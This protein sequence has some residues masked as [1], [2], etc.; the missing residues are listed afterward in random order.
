MNEPFAFPS[1]PLPQPDAVTAI[2]FRNQD[3]EN[4]AQLGLALGSILSTDMNRLVVREWMHKKGI[5]RGRV[6]KHLHNIEGISP[7]FYAIKRNSVESVYLLADLGFDPNAVAFDDEIP[8]L[9]YAIMCSWVHLQNST[10]IVR[11]LLSIGTR[12]KSVPRE[13]WDPIIEPQSEIEV[14]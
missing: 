12:A 14:T 10:E 5:T 13:M 4:F 7:Y 2:G 8:V 11:A 3:A 6:Q 9:A 1:L